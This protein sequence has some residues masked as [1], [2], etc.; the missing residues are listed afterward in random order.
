MPSQLT[1]QYAAENRLRSVRMLQPRGAVSGGFYEAGVPFTPANPYAGVNVQ[2]NDRTAVLEG[3][4]AYESDRRMSEL[5]LR[6]E[7]GVSGVQN[8]ISVAP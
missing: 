1:R 8:R 7:P 2:I 6:L 4:V 5:L 3:T